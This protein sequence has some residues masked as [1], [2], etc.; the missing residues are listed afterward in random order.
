MFLTPD[1]P[2]SYTDEQK[3]RYREYR[4]MTKLPHGKLLRDGR[5]TKLAYEEGGIDKQIVLP[6]DVRV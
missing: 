6:A 1:D 2:G 4:E 5:R 3:K